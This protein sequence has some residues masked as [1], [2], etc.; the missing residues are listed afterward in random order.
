[1]KTYFARLTK[2]FTQSKDGYEIISDN[3]I[4]VVT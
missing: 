3:D 1:M 4:L 2:E